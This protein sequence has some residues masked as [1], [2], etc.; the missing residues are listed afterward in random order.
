ML[1][2]IPGNSHPVTY[3]EMYLK[4]FVTS[5][6]PNAIK[7]GKCVGCGSAETVRWSRYSNKKVNQSNGCLNFIT[8]AIYC[9]ALAII[10]SIS[11]TV[12]L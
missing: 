1:Y 9:C 12:G 7:K 2:S 5:Q 3:F 10:R 6:C 8:S 11:F 4:I